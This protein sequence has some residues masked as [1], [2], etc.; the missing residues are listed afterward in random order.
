MQIVRFK[1]TSKGIRHRISIKKSLLSKTNKFLKY[2][3]FGL[4]NS[5]GRSSNTGRITVRHIGGGCKKKFRIINFS[6]TEKSS[7]VV[8]IMYDPFRSSFTSLHFDI[9]NKTFCRSL[10]TNNVN[11]GSLLRC[12]SADVELKLGNR[13]MLKNIPTGSILH[14]LSLC[15]TTRYARSAGLF[16]QIIQKSPQ[17]CQIRLPSGLVKEVSS[18]SFGTLGVVSNSQHNSIVI[19][20]AGRNRLL[21][22]RPKIRGIAM[23]PVDHP[24]GGRS[25]G[26]KPV[27]PW[28]IPTRGKPTVKN[29]K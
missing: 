19:G 6:N 10:A 29:K 14:S 22:K 20:K 27:T 2:S 24:H 12:D 3:I 28:G 11:V 25:N 9:S 13:T 17:T 16:F 7:L 21:G 26:G 1:P 23:N 5:S 4:K 18:N 15:F 8:S